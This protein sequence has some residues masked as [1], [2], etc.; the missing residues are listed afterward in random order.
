MQDNFFDPSLY[1]VQKSIPQLDGIVS[2]NNGKYCFEG[3]FHIINPN[4]PIFNEH[5]LLVGVTNPR[6]IVHVHSYGG[7]AEFFEGLHNGKL[8]ATQCENLACDGFGTV[9]QPFRTYCP[10]CLEKNT[11]IN[12]TPNAMESATIY[13]FMVTER[14][15]AFNTLEKPV[16]FINIEFKGV[17]TILMGPLIA[18][19]PKIGDR[20]V[21]IFKIKPTY[22]IIDLLWVPLGT[23]DDRIPKG[24]IYCR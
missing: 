1:E 22:T 19:N 18:G 10:D 13:S 6:Q 16:K 4:R 17:S 3:N 12:L 11:V 9:Y 20:V 14:T 2:V 7:E 15:G 23:S 21:P 8:Y 5:G 24:Y